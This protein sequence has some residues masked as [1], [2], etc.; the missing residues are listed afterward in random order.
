MVNN[1]ATRSCST[2]IDAVDLQK[3]VLP[4]I[5][6]GPPSKSTVRHGLVLESALMPVEVTSVAET[7][8][9]W[10]TLVRL[11]WVV[12]VCLLAKMRRGEVVLVQAVL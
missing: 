11:K 3:E 12:S 4:S 2:S 9:A 6:S 1:N 5:P 8:M 10:V 7:H